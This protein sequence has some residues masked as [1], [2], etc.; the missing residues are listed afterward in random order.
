LGVYKAAPE[1]DVPCNITTAASGTCPYSHISSN[2]S[3]NLRIDERLAFVSAAQL[4][5][6]FHSEL[7][8]TSRASEWQVLNAFLLA[9]AIN[10]ADQLVRQ[11]FAAGSSDEIT[12]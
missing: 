9:S 7:A 3:L 5:V 8:L 1:V 10:S 4:L 12:Y 6:S 11:C 2:C